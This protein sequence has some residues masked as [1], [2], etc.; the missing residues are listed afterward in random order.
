MTEDKIERRV[1]RA[2]DRLDARLMSGRL[3]Q[4]E[5]DREVVILDKWASQQYRA[6]GCEP[7][8]RG[9]EGSNDT[10]FDYPG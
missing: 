2:M 3:S 9:Y 7:D 10:N 4:A 1:E 8:A 5:Y 6:S